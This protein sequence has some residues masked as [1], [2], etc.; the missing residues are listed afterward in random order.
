[1]LI[2]L[3]FT[4][5]LLSVFAV[6]GGTAVLH[7]MQDVLSA[8]FGIGPQV[9]IKTYG[10]GQ[11]APGPNMTMVVL[12]G[13]QIGGALAAVVAGLAFFVP[14]SVLCL[15]VGRVWNRIGET[16]W[17]RAVQNGL[18]PISIG[19]MCSG[20]YAVAKT[21]LTGPITV[22]LAVLSYLLIVRTRT[23]PIAVILGLGAAGG[24]LSYLLPA[25]R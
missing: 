9:F 14:S 8:Q 15:W 24:A 17:R 7:E 13:A 4:F 10:I 16:P 22:A 12:L 3:A 11:L 6:G 5:V 25:W 21:A 23:S 20:I 18:E 2:K 19:L 1:M